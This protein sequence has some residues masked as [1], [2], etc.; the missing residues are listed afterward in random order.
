MTWLPDSEHA[1]G[2]TR[3]NRRTVLGMVFLF[4]AIVFAFLGFRGVPRNNAYVSL[5]AAFAIIAAT[6]FRRART[7]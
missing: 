4:V 5:G 2:G 3:M 6:Q 7:S 1:Q